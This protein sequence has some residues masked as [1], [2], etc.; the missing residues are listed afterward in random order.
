MYTLHR[1][2][3]LL[4]S[5]YASVAPVLFA[6]PLYCALYTKVATEL[7]ERLAS[8]DPPLTA[9]ENTLIQT[10]DLLYIPSDNPRMLLGNVMHNLAR[11]LVFL[12][13]SP[14]ACT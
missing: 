7:A 14:H 4:L 8:L 10:A 1:Y 5:A 12:Q 2:S 11:T 6:S 3:Q 9:D 13:A